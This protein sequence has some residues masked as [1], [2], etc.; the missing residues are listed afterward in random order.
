MEIYS[1]YGIMMEILHTKT[2]LMQLRILTSDIALELGVMTVF[3]KQFYL[4][5]KWLP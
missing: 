2:L 1:Q 5:E 4:V 3:T